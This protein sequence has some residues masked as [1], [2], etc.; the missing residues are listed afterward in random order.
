MYN[1][2]KDITGQ[3]FGKWF[4]IS[5]APKSNRKNSTPAMWNVICDCGTKALVSGPNL[6]SGATKSCPCSTRGPKPERIGRYSRERHHAWKGGKSVDNHGY[7]VLTNSVVH[8]LY[9]K[10]S[11]RDGRN[12]RRM[13][14]HQAVMSHH[15]ERPLHKDETIHHKNGDRGDNRLENLEL[16]A[17][18]HGPG[19]TI[20]DLVTWAKEILKRYDS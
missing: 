19:Q 7:I 8:D 14:E 4:V 9:P 15:L 6:R 13:F 5:R 1:T 17:G 10:A 2:A 12:Q 18:K 16:R 11:W 20:Q 3:R